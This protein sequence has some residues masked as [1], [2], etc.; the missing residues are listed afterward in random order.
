M[1][2]EELLNSLRCLRCGTRE[3]LV[4]YKYSKDYKHSTGGI[5]ISTVHKGTKSVKV[6]FCY[7]CNK[8]IKRWE[9]YY[10][11][12]LGLLLVFELIGYFVSHFILVG[13]S[14]LLSPF[15]FSVSFFYFLGLMVYILVLFGSILIFL[16]ANQNNP[17]TYVEFSGFEPSVRPMNSVVWIPYRL[18][19]EGTVLDLEI[20]SPTEK[21]INTLAWIFPLV[22]GIVLLISIVMPTYYTFNSGVLKLGWLPSIVFYSE[23]SYLVT[24]LESVSLAI[25]IVIPPFEAFIPTFSWIIYAIIL[26]GSYIIIKKAYL[27]KRIKH[28]N[29]SISLRNL[30][31]G[32]IVIILISFYISLNN[33]TLAMTIMGIYGIYIGGALVII[34]SI[35]QFM[36]KRR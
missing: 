18:W 7:N 35:L 25:F 11:L 1:S 28:F 31:F 36:A 33:L 19:I 9:R 27:L 15:A 30:F 22:G 2:E 5:P 32:V 26:G 14:D 13:A 4:F 34:G 8:K 29:K 16:L 20:D 6:P 3:S 12:T 17:R 23:T 24:Y 21:S 10:Y